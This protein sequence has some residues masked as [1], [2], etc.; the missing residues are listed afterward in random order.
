[1]LKASKLIH[2]EWGTIRTD[3]WNLKPQQTISE[4][5]GSTVKKHLA[6]YMLNIE[7]LFAEYK[8]ITLPLREIF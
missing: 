4:Q 3:F 7:N 6:V 8:K 5:K 2:F 1:M